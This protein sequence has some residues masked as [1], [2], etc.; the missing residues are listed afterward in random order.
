M[1]DAMILFQQDHPAP[2]E[3]DQSKVLTPAGAAAL[4]SVVAQLKASP[5]TQARLIG[6][7]SS[8]GATDY[9]Q[10][11]AARRVAFVVAA[12]GGG[13]RYADP[14]VSDGA[15]TGCAQIAAGQWSCGETQADQATAAPEDRNVQVTFLAAQA[16]PGGGAQGPKGGAP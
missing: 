9:N 1:P 4:A 12:L 14:P 2:G 8:E 10:A 3:R 15:E 5:S 16:S 11:L 6:R 13:G 7:A